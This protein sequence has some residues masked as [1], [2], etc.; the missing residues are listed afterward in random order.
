MFVSGFIGSP[1][2]NFIPGEVD[3]RKLR[4]PFATITLND[5]QALAVAGKSLVMA[6]IRPEHFEDSARIT[7]GRT[8]GGVTFDA[9]VDVTEW[10][11]NEQYAYVPYEAPNDV[12]NRLKD[13]ARELD[14]DAL[15]TQLVA[16][17]D[18]QSR[19]EENEKASFWLDTSR[20]HL[21]DLESGESLLEAR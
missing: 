1:P 16:A 19:I 4:L 17:V 14:S 13:L 9:I 10:L 11:G 15:R 8:A 18:P 7:D 6:G 12:A 5:V 2:M 21:F 20:L 3:G